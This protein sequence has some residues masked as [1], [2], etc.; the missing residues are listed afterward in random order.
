MRRAGLHQGGEIRA[1]ARQRSPVA[2]GNTLRSL[3]WLTFGY[4]AG[5]DDVVSMRI[6]HGLV[7]VLDLTAERL[8]AVTLSPNS[9][10]LDHIM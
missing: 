10:A 6:R 4:A 9:I 3:C 2:S 7:E 1:T 5:N 8:G